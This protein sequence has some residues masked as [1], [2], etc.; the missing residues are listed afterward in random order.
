MGILEMEKWELPYKYIVSEYSEVS[1]YTYFEF[2]AVKFPEIARELKNI[3]ANEN[4]QK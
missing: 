4:L 1:L 2:N 3:K